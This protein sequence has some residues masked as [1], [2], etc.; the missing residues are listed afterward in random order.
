LGGFAVGALAG[1]A[2][3]LGL[4]W[5]RFGQ[6]L[7]TGYALEADTL[8]LAGFEVRLF[9]LLLSPYRGLAW[10]MPLALL[11][12]LGWAW[13]WGRRRAEAALSL[14]LCAAVVGVYS[15]WTIWWGGVNWGP[16]YLAP[17]M[18]FV[19][20]GL[21]P[22]WERALARGGWRLGGMAALAG[23]S[24][25]VQLVGA[26]TDYIVHDYAYW[27]DYTPALSAA[28]PVWTMPLLY[29]P[30][31]S[32]I[33]LQSADL[34]R[35]RVDLAWVTPAGTDWTALGL[36]LLAVVGAAGGL[37][38][39]LRRR[40]AAPLAGGGL[41][42]VLVV[43]LT[44]PRAAISREPGGLEAVVGEVRAQ[45]RPGD[46][47]VQMLPFHSGELANFNDLDLPVYGLPSQ[48]APLRPEMETLLRQLTAHDR[49]V[50][51]LSSDSPVAD[52][53][54][55]TE[56][57]LVAHAY[58]FY[59][60]YFGRVRVS[61][62]YALAEAPAPEPRTETFGEAI[63]LLA[64]QRPENDY[65][66]GDVVTLASAWQASQPITQTL[67]VFVHVQDAAGTVVAQRDAAP[68]DG[69]A[70][71][72]DWAV[73]ATVTDRLGVRLPPDLPA[74]EYRVYLGWYDAFTGV[75]LPMRPAQAED[76]LLAG[77]IMVE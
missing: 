65:R 29:D 61:G 2:V 45:A 52:P 18:P 4:N 55:S 44:L 59:H 27:L 50:W 56:A 76:R 66:P 19:C 77:I 70:P 73:G 62:F 42:F 3:M 23:L 10:Y 24:V 31:L 46:V 28:A 74:G 5:L 14:A 30:R 6:W 47:I 8:R 11:A 64:L 25:W 33:L 43:G 40:T 1:V 20:L 32:P 68:Q 26:T 38:W 16:R 17:L 75:R 72:T 63:W 54:N 60:G 39:T 35:G 36:G 41:L 48:E 69:Y 13:L 15:L 21:A 34:L 12:P 9:G 67:N 49:A 71:A 51:V 57:W 53:L 37:G 7:E 58:K 22:V